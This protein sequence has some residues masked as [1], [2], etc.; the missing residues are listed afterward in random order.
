MQMCVLISDELK[1][2]YVFSDKWVPL[3]TAW[4]VLELRVEE[5]PP[6]M[7]DSFEYIE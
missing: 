7:K 3:T 1:L 5:R 6:N 4:R 2:E